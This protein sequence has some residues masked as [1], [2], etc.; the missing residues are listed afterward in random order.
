MSMLRRLWWYC[1][2]FLAGMAAGPAVAQPP[3]LLAEGDAIVSNA[4]QFLLRSP[5]LDREFVVR[6]SVTPKAMLAERGATVVYLPDGNWYFGLTT[7]IA[8]ML[9][10]G[11]GP[12]IVIV[13][14][15]YP[16]DEFEAVVA[17]RETDLVHR[18]FAGPTGEVGG[19][20]ADF[21]SF[22]LEDL[23]PFIEARFPVD[24]ERTILA[25][26][27]LGGLFAANVL[28][29]Q[30]ESFAGYLIGSPSLWADASVLPGAE[31][32]EDGH[33][34]PVFVGVGSGESPRMRENTA[35]LAAALAKESASLRVEA[36]VL[37]GKH[38]VSMQGAWFADGLQY[39][40]ETMD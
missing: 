30:P 35:K 4:Q 14:V 6:V 24:P 9:E 31:T 39:L 22:I 21:L 37:E 13:A 27:S 38:H 34:R 28:L 10:I 1:L 2:A 3:E 19:G 15:G 33:G 32:F 7:D 16:V 36:A 29:S 18:R 12:P 20:G 5:R 17:L 40:L 26:Q 11:G 8:R 25:G 23:S